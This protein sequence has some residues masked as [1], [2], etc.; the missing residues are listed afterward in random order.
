MKHSVSALMIMIVV[1]VLAG[2]SK[3][4]YRVAKLEETVKRQ[5]EEIRQLRS[6]NEQQVED[7]QLKAEQALQDEN[8]A[9]A[10][11]L[12]K[13]WGG[14]CNKVDISD[15]MVRIYLCSIRTVASFL[16]S[17]PER[18]ARRDLNFFLEETGLKTGMIEYFTPKK[19]K[20]FSISGSLSSVETKRYE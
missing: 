13:R 8:K 17:G 11:A 19:F 6:K 7:E 15:E 12:R 3:S 5:E 18:H 1:S 9:I 20:F 4:E 2:C 14:K 16:D 10:W